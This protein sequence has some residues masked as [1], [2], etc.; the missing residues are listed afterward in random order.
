MAFVVS[1]ISGKASAWANPLWVCGNP[2]MSC[3]QEFLAMF[4]RVFRERSYAS[5]AGSSFLHQ[6][7]GNYIV[8][9]NLSRNNEALVD[10][11]SEGLT[12]RVKVEQT[13][14]DLLTILDNLI[15]LDSHSL[16]TK[17]MSISCSQTNS[18]GTLS[19]TNF[20]KTSCHPHILPMKSPG[21][22]RDLNL[23]WRS[24]TTDTRTIYIF[25]MGVKDHFLRECPVKLGNSST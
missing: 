9:S 1:L 6:C 24:V 25:I 19:G 12:G 4:H 8:A 14:R 7:Q 23:P 10:I 11:F 3:L 18:P 2:V 5:S 22:L 16:S 17:P 15:T 21:K 13:D 20:S